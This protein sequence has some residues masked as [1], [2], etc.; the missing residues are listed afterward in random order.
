MLKKILC[1]AVSAVMILG[2]FVS[3]EKKMV[4]LDDVEI[5]NFSQP[6]QGEEIAVI[7]VKDYG[8]I[9]I[10]LFPE[11]CPNGVENFKTLINNYEYYDS[12]IFHRV[13][14]EFMIQGG[15]PSGTGSDGKSMWGTGFSQEINS[16]LCHFSGAVAYAV[17]DDKLNGSQFYIVT[18]LTDISNEDFENLAAADTPKYYPS[19]V[20]DMYCEKGGYPYLDGDYEVFGQVFEG[21]DICFEIASVETDDN[22]KPLE[23]IVI[24]KAEIVEYN[25]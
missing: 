24:E 12:T 23:D 9:K 4:T 2:T 16:G 7:T 18:G 22:D 3:C 11:Q 14:E 5:L 1:L 17:G 15:D 21:L 10:K 20:I 6:Q 19:N 8:D 13:I 25:G